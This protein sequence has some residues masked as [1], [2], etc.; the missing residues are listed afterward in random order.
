MTRTE[1]M[2]EDFRRELSAQHDLRT[3][4]SW[5][6]GFMFG[7]LIFGGIVGIGFLMYVFEHRLGM[8]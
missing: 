7:V 6:E 8:S 5:L 4:V 2:R 1:K 3:D